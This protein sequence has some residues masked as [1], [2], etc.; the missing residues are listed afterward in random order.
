LLISNYYFDKDD[1]SNPIKSYIEDTIY[2][3][4]LPENKL[5]TDIFVSIAEAK[6]SSSLLPWAVPEVKH[7][8]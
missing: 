3:T 8:T 4:V 1:D 5:Q 2:F 7:F 6:L